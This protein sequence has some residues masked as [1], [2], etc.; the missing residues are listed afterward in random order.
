MSK[1]ESFSCYNKKN[2]LRPKMDMK[3]LINRHQTPF[4]FTH[5]HWAENILASE[6]AV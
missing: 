6:F 1:V 2:S 5:L 4:A 3:A